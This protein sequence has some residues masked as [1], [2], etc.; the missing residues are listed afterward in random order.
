MNKKTEY[1]K[2]SEVPIY[3]KIEWICFLAM[4]IPFVAIFFFIFIKLYTYDKGKVVGLDSK[5]RALLIII[6]LLSIYAFIKRYNFY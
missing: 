3:R 4:L 1:E 2:Y 6:T 5:A